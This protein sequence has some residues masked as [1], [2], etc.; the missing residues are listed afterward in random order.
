[1]RELTK[2]E[3]GS[4]ITTLWPPSWKMDMTSQLCRGWSYLDKILQADV[5]WHAVGNANVKVKP[6]AEFQHGGSLFSVTGGSN[7]SAVGWYIWPKSGLHVDFDQPKWAR[8]R[9][10][11]PEVELRCCS[12]HFKNGYDVITM[13]KWC[14]LDEIWQA[15]AEWHAADDAIVKNQ[16]RK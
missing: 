2:N 15:V 9:Q 4:R 10:T 13:S 6:E 16:N 1:M 3:T 12:H 5:E 8:S 7:I 11:K 14:D